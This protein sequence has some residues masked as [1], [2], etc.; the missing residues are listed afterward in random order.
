MKVT[1]VFAS[2]YTSGK[3]IG[4]ADV[5]FSLDGSDGNHMTMRGFK[6]FQG[7]N[8]ITLGFP[9]KIEA[10]KEDRSKVRVNKDTG[11]VEYYPVVSLAKEENGGPSTDFMEHV[12]SAVETAYYNL[13]NQKSS[14]KRTTPS[15]SGIDEDS[16]PF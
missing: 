12:R 5:Q 4:F 3:L 6:L 13:D 14:E 11:K 10:D 9:Q 1:R 15:D 7:D 8:G 2:K 16:L